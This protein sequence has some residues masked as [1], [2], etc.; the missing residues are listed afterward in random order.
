MQFEVLLT[1]KHSRSSLAVAHSLAHRSISFLV[2]SD[3]PRCLVSYSRYIK[4][5]MLSPS[6]TRQPDLFIEFVLKLINK[7]NIKLI[8]PITDKTLFSIERAQTSFR[9]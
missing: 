3:N 2:L 7:H 6:L 4:H 1:E 5:F 8:M 9:R